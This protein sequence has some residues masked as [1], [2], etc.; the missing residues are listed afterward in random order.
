MQTQTKTT[1]LLMQTYHKHCTT[2]L[3]DYLLAGG[4]EN[5]DLALEVISYKRP[6]SIDLFR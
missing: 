3:L 1:M 6:Q 2:M 5:N 4:K